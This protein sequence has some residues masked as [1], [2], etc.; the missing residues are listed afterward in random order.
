MSGQENLSSFS[1]GKRQE[2]PS[3]PKKALKLRRQAVQENLRVGR[4]AQFGKKVPDAGLPQGADT[5][6]LR[7]PLAQRFF[8]DRKRQI[9]HENERNGCEKTV[10]HRD[11]VDRPF[12]PGVDDA[13]QNVGENRQEDDD[14][15]EVGP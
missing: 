15:R 14:E 7:L 10:G 3:G 5:L 12:R 4:L 9:P 11:R 13:G 1:V 8:L 2:D 6:R